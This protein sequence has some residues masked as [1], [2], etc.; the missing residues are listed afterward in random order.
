MLLRSISFR[1]SLF[2]VRRSSFV[3]RGEVNQAEISILPNQR[4]TESKSKSKRNEK[5]EGRKKKKAQ[6]S[7]QADR[8]YTYKHIKYPSNQP[9]ERLSSASR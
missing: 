8:P 3:R 1:R 7:K 4:E 5:E 9:F 6:A 2:D